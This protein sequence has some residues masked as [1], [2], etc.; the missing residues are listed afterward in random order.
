MNNYLH[1]EK[2]VIA[3]RSCLS[4]MKTQQFLEV[5]LH[6][7]E[8]L[9]ISKCSMYVEYCSTI[10]CIELV[11]FLSHQ[12]SML[13]QVE[14]LKKLAPRKALGPFDPNM[15][16]PLPSTM[17]ND[18]GKGTTS[19]VPNRGSAQALD[20]ESSLA[21]V[22]MNGE[23]APLDLSLKV[24]ARFVSAESLHWWVFVSYLMSL[25]YSII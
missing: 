9:T 23:S 20:I 14:A 21:W 4:Q 25:G 8:L 2:L 1:N 11:I 22:R 10:F 7:F 6:F 18:G 16:L 5:I 15:G 12:L 3:L 19:N 17:Y 24:V 13:L